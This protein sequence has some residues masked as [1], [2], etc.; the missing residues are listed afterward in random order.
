ME[1]K[2]KRSGFAEKMSES[3][4]KRNRVIK[5]KEARIISITVRTI[6]KVVICSM[7]P[8]IVKPMNNNTWLFIM[9]TAFL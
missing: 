4:H 5:A 8:F 2:K 6:F 3:Q 7:P 9:Q 1:S